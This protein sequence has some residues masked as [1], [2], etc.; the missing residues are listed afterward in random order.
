MPLLRILLG[1]SL[2][3][4]VQPAPAADITID[5]YLPD[6]FPGCTHILIHDKL[7]LI[8][9]GSKFFVRPS[10]SE[11]FRPAPLT[12]FDDAHSVAF[13][14]RTGLYYATDT[15]HHRMVSFRDPLTDR[16]EKAAGTIAGIK[17]DRPHD[18]V[19]DDD[20]WLH[21]LNPNPPTTVFRLRDFGIEETAL[22]L[23]QHLGYSR[24]L[25][26]V[27]NRLYVIG[28]SVGK[29]IEVTDFT[30]QEFAVH[31]SFGKKKDAP[32]GSWATTGLVPNDADQFDG[33]WY[34]TSYFCPA[35]AQGTD[36]NQHKLVR[37]K[38]W[39]DFQTGRWEDL[40]PL[41]PDKIVPYYLTPTAEALLIA[42]FEHEDPAHP[43]GVWRVRKK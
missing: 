43:G 30:K 40:S 37:F 23:S 26:V 15:A 19:A 33:W 18:V 8:T 13:F 16:K 1:A 11:P 9:A 31:D 36:H 7:E 22:D 35:Y 25:S 17:L 28:S 14:S 27:K 32:A 41:L 24:S 5:R 4:A 3:V 39:D 38:T 10:F 21:V 6:N 34:V 2:I 12:G 29:I 20:G 42:A